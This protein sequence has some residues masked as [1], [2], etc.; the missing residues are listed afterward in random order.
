MASL[1]PG[2]LI[3][4]DGAGFGHFWPLILLGYMG[5]QNNHEKS[6][7]RERVAFLKRSLYRVPTVCCIQEPSR[8]PSWLFAG[9]LI[10][11]F[12]EGITL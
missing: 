2:F 12:T 5:Y 6:R 11:W 4:S 9:V 8:S 10:E 7:R 3:N 1:Y